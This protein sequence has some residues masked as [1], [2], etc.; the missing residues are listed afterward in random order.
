MQ[1]LDILHLVLHR[2][3]HRRPQGPGGFLPAAYC[4]P[5]LPIHCTGEHRADTVVPAA[6]NLFRKDF[7]LVDTKRAAQPAQCPQNPQRLG[8]LGLVAPAPFPPG[9][10][11][12]HLFPCDG[13]ANAVEAFQQHIQRAVGVAAAAPGVAQRLGLGQVGRAGLGYHRQFGHK[14]L[15]PHIGGGGRQGNIQLVGYLFG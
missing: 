10:H 9:V 1:V 5:L 2:Q 11:C 3:Q 15:P 4:H 13:V 8:N 6:F 12:Q 7:H 14:G